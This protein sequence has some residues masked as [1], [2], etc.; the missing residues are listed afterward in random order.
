VSASILKPFKALLAPTDEQLMWRAQQEDDAE[1]FASLVTRWQ[2]TIRRLCARL[3]GDEHRAE[4]LAQEVFAKVFLRR[5][6]FRQGSKFSTYLWRIA[7]NH[8][9][10]DLRRPVHRYERAFDDED[11]AGAAPD[12]FPGEQPTPDEAAT[13]S[14]IAHAV[15]RALTELP[16]QYR[17]IVVLRHYEDLKF[18][19]IAEVTDLPEGT[20]KTRLT[21]ALSE[22]ARRLRIPLDLRIVPPPGR[23]SR[24]RES[25]GL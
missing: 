18:R 24:P 8:C 16:E 2:D 4:D 10:N 19:E 6:A 17:T 7:L 14:E 15:R 21:E 20:V 23:R 11:G 13:S 12:R 3:T 1:A 9:Y 22:L 25:L 5:K